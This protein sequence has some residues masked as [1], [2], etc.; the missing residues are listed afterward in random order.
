MSGSSQSGGTDFDSSR[1]FAFTLEVM[2]VI[3]LDAIV[4]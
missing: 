1:Y 4:N 2:E 3:T